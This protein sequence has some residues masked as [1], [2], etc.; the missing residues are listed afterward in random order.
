[1]PGV[2]SLHHCADG[3]LPLS[4][5]ATILQQF[6]TSR[7]SRSE[8]PA[9]AVAPSEARLAPRYGVVLVSIA[10]VFEN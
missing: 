2:E 5:T 7:V 8:L 3:L 1:M 10:T 4:A 9:P 6:L